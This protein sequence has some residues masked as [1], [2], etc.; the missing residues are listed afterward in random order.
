MQSLCSKKDMEASG[1]QM[2][3]MDVRDRAA[4]MLRLNP[5][6]NGSKYKEGSPGHNW[7]AG[8]LKRHP[9]RSDTIVFSFYTKDKRAVK[10]VDHQVW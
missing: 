2:K 9:G 5:R 4:E 3:C 10:S 8:F 6:S 7:L 1:F